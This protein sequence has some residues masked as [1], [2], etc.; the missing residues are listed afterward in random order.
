[1]ENFSIDITKHTDR[2]LMLEAAEATFAGN[3]NQ[4]LASMYRS[5]HS[6]ARTQMFMIKLEDIP[7]YVST[8]LLRHH[9][10]SQPF[11]LTHRT[12]RNGGGFDLPTQVKSLKSMFNEYTELLTAGEVGTEVQTRIF[13]ELTRISDK[14]GRMTPTNLSLFINAQSLID[15]ARLRICNKASLHTR[16]T[17]NAIREELKKHDAELVPFLVRTCVYRNGIC[18]ETPCGFTRTKEWDTEMSEYLKNFTKKQQ[19]PSSVPL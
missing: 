19:P 13:D 6:P 17:F 15:M 9:V 5:E 16:V 10:G 7:L 8:H 14:G 18:N 4:T 3:S 11:A 12:D 2:S 1:M